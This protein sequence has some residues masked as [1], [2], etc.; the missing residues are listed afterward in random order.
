MLVIDDPQCR[1]RHRIEDLIGIE[2]L[3]DARRHVLQ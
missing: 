3:D 1:L 2:A